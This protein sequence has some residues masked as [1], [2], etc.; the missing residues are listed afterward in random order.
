[1]VLDWKNRTDVAIVI[2]TATAAAIVSGTV[3]PT[4]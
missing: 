4:F 1:M 3:T 2:T